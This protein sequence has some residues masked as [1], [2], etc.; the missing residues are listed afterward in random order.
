MTDDQPDA[1][2]DGAAETE[3]EYDFGFRRAAAKVREFPQTP[4]VYLMK[5]S[6]GRVIY[7]GKAKSL[8]SR[9]GSYFQK[10][11][12]EERRTAPWVRDLVW[13]KPTVSGRRRRLFLIIFVPGT[14]ATSRT[15]LHQLR[16]LIN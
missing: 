4:G 6:A 2:D 10:G 16:P 8:R 15:R 14:Q 7:V 13:P 12:E 9:A 11:A 3:R 5:D 1:R